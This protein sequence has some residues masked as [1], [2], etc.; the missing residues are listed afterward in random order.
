MRLEA[1]DLTFG[2]S[3]RRSV[4]SNVSIAINSG[5]MMFV[6]GANGSGKTTLVECL[7]GLRVPHQ[8]DVRLDGRPIL[9]LP[10]CD[11]AQAVGIVPQIHEPV[12]EYTVG[13][14]ALMGRAP[15]LTML[16]RPGRRDW[17]AVRVALDR[18]GLLP[19]IDRPYTQTSGGERQLTLIA[20]G[21]AQGA[22]CLLM[23]EP[24]AHLD[25][26]YQHRILSTIDGLAA[27]EYAFVVTSHHPNNALSYAD[28]VAFL[29]DGR[30][31]YFGSPNRMI[32]EES[33]AAAYGMEFDIISSPGVARAVVPRAPARN[34]AECACE[35]SAQRKENP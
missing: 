31:D 29:I 5:E 8:G 32:C 14:V 17:D 13:E 1:R 27:D 25:P 2:Y 21:L 10:L 35:D 15:Q 24:A 6:L 3:A 18:V 19:L 26:R 16:S 20:R 30:A 4:L 22:R 7:A 23:D 28:V 34:R 11:R 9:R 33:L 12:F